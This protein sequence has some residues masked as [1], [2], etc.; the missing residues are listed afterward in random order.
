MLVNQKKKKNTPYPDLMKIYTHYL[1]FTFIK[2]SAAIIAISAIV[3]LES[4]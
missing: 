2:D 4:E 1:H 3:L